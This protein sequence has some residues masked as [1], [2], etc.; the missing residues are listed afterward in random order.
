LFKAEQVDRAVWAWVKSLLLEPDALRKTIEDQQ[1]QGE[2]VGPKLV[3]LENVAMQVAERKQQ[4][5]RLID[6]YSKG[7]LSLD[8]L[9]NQKALLDKELNVLHGAASLLRDEV[10][11]QT[12]SP[13]R[14]ELYIGDYAPKSGVQCKLVYT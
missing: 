5:A 10:Q 11:V 13:G 14:C 12:F 4:K 6:A 1:Q 3:M 8:E 7:I 9:A 2:R